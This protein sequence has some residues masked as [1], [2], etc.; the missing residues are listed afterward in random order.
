MPPDSTDAGAVYYH[1]LQIWQL[2]R[3]EVEAMLGL[4]LQET[5]V[6]QEAKTEG[7]QIGEQRGRQQEATSLVS[8]LLT[9][10]LNQELSAEVKAQ[11]E[12]LPLAQ[13][14]RLTETLLDFTSLDELL[15]WLGGNQTSEGDLAPEI[16][17]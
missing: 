4:T 3:V 12:A 13:L 10:R 9:R 6:Y 11:V 8:R 1:D 15:T 7:E 17:D 2:S 16:G 14:E 5:R